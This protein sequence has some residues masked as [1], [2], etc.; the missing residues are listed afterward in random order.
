MGRVQQPEIVYLDTHILM[1]LYDGLVEKIS[2]LAQEYL[3]TGHLH[4]SPMAELEL[5]YLHEIG[6]V[7]PTA[8]KVVHAL[9]IDL[10]LK[11]GDL[12][13]GD[14]VRHAL[15]LEWTRDPFDRLI[16][17]E[18]S[19]ANARLITRDETIRMHYQLATW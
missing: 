19:L 2:P 10:G 8:Q 12:S 7:K 3:I 18:A 17:A 16:V 6:R 15:K 9:Q 14:V 1:W 13:F 11:R 5:Q 4:L